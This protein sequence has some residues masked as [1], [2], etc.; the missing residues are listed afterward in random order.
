MKNK[1]KNKNNS[2]IKL[3]GTCATAGM[4][5]LS[6]FNFGITPINSISSVSAQST[7]FSVVTVT[8]SDFDNTSSSTY[9]K[10]ASSWTVL[11]SDS[12]ANAGVISTKESEFNSYYKKYYKINKDSI[13]N[14]NSTS[15]NVFMMNAGE[16]RA[17]Y[18]IESSS[19]DLSANSN[20]VISFDVKTSL[21]IL[22]DEGN[23]KPLTS[24]ASAYLKIGDKIVASKLNVNTN[25]EW[26]TFYFFIQTSFKESSTAYLQLYLGSKEFQSTG[27]ILFDSVT[28]TK[29]TNSAFENKNSTVDSSKK[30]S[31]VSDSSLNNV[32]Y[33]NKIDITSSFSDIDT[34][35]TDA[36]AWDTTTFGNN[37]AVLS[38]IIDV[39]DYDSNI[40]KISENPKT[41][42]SATDSKIMFL[43]VLSS[44]DLSGASVNLTSKK[45]LT[46]KRYGNYLIQFYVKTSSITGAG[47]HVSLVPEN[48]D[49]YS[50]VS[51]SSI[52]SSTNS[53]TNDWTVCSLYVQGNSFEDVQAKLEIGLG[54]VSDET[55][56][57]GYAF[58]DDLHVYEIDYSDYEN[59]TTSSTLGKGAFT[60]DEESSD[61]LVE[62]FNFN[63][64]STS[65]GS[66]SPF[67]PANWTASNTNSTDSGIINNQKATFDTVSYGISWDAVGLTSAQSFIDITNAV[68][69]DVANQNLLMLNTTKSGYQSYTSDSIS[70]EASKLYKLSIDAK[71]LADGAY[72]NIK[73]G[74]T[75][76]ESTEIKKSTSFNLYDFYF[77][78]SM[79]SESLTIELGL[80]TSEKNS[81]GFAF[82]DAIMLT[83]ITEDS[84]LE[85][86]TA[87]A[88]Y[89]KLSTTIENF[90][91]INLYD[92]FFNYGDKNSYGLYD[93]FSWDSTATLNSRAGIALDDE[94]TP[95]LL[96]STE[97][98]KASFTVK[99]K[100][101]YSLTESYYKVSFSLETTNFD[102]LSNCG[103][104]FGFE[105]ASNDGNY[106]T[107]IISSEESTY[108]FYI[109]TEDSDYSSLT[110]YITI[111]TNDNLTTQTVK[112]TKLSFESISETTYSTLKAQYED[113]ESTEDFSKTILL[114]STDEEADESEEDA[115]ES[116][117]SSSSAQVWTWFIP[118]II[119]VLA[120]ILAMIAMI[121]KKVNRKLEKRGKKYKNTYDR[122][123]TIHQSIIDKEVNELI[124]AK[125][126][127]KTAQLEKE[128]AILQE[129]EDDYKEN[130]NKTESE[131]KKLVRNRKRHA[132]K[133]EQLEEEIKHIQSDEFIQEATNE[134]LIKH[135]EEIEQFQK[136]NDLEKD[137]EDTIYMDKA[138]DVVIIDEK[139]S[140]E[141]DTKSNDEDKK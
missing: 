24:L 2:A 26:A 74:D 141:N 61:S 136:D 72:I 12:V 121:M 22:D 131:Y 118:T 120:L 87:T 68:E 40:T 86:F 122:E 132:K 82:F 78:T 134:V 69:L 129:M 65:A 21:T 106:F 48:D 29:Y 33:R 34:S 19:F 23:E 41:N 105:E 123:T 80:G 70:L 30:V 104:T 124:K 77:L 14:E 59:A 128:Q 79:S 15:P 96:I 1:T 4:V 130:S 100:F 98:N 133:K 116:E 99:S 66:T 16:N 88:E 64:I 94:N 51:L 50:S 57:S 32:D 27:A 67:A 119:T 20:Y 110:P 43:N 103:V 28:C 114:S 63:D 108:E 53:L 81:P 39:N 139:S 76:I 35:F 18:G 101:T 75:L 9:P 91:G 36:T 95:Y 13:A 92:N 73:Y 107:N 140:E 38:G 83:A 52:S 93:S 54:S 37:S 117:D 85:T 47:L 112:L 31:Y 3:F 138:E 55:V 58:I 11:T 137:D 127:E 42:N 5:A 25:N 6:M 60:K 111:T 84:S 125:V 56:A 8:N 71:S 113:E 10:T 7:D 89:D 49:D 135:E 44:K 102:D 97:D 17:S 126:A 115:E 46:I 62:N 109:K 45:T 90:N